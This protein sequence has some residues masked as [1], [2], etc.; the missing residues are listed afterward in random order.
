MRWLE[1]IRLRSV[2]IGEGSLEEF[3]RSLVKS[4]RSRELVEI[5]T[6]RHAFLANDVSVHLHWESGRP[7]Q[8]GT[9]LGLRLGQALKE[10]GLTDHSSWIEEQAKTDFEPSARG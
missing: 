6:Y 7:E 10:F 9:A 1:I 4:S 8:D 3:L 5:K 2:G